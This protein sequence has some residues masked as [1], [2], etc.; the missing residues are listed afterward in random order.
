MSVTWHGAEPPPPR[1]LGP[2]E[3]LRLLSRGALILS[4]LAICFPLLLLLRLPERA[5]WGLRRP[6][7]PWITQAV[8]IA[9]CRI[10]G[11]RRRVH[12]TVFTGEGA[13]TAN[14][15]TWLDIFVLNACTRLYFVA[16][17]DVHAWPGIGWL[18]RATGTLFISRDRRKAAEQARAMEDR[19]IAGHKLLLFP[20]GTCS[21]GRRVLPFR[22]TLFQSF[23]SNRLRD[24]LHVQPIS[25]IYHPPPGLP[26]QYF[27]WWGDMAFGPNLIQMLGGPG[28]GHVDVVFH[29]AQPVRAFEGRKI[30]ADTIERQTRQGFQAFDLYQENKA[31]GGEAKALS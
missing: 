8:C 22:S 13:F 14:H 29:T 17:D 16:K 9:T 28:G 30:L 6:V 19:L 24:D 26:P 12:G 21:D 18:A 15:S 1:P 11:L 25:V 7:T 4:I 10:L 2:M 20:E 3:G 27:G 23:F 5:I 31:E